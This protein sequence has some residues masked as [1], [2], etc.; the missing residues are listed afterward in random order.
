[1][2]FSLPDVI[3][4]SVFLVLFSGAIMYYVGG[5]VVEQASRQRLSENVAANVEEQKNLLE[6]W[7][8]EKERLVSEAHAEVERAQAEVESLRSQLEEVKLK[9]REGVQN[10]TREELDDF[11]ADRANR[12]DVS[13]G[14]GC[15][16][17]ES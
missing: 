16:G 12:V 5:A 2:V 14:N 7:V 17:S 3:T 9:I 4:L 6:R 15:S 13:S 1:M 8:A 11:F 10:E